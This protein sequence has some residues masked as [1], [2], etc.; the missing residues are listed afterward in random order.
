MSC[1][2]NKTDKI[3]TLTNLGLTHT[4]AKV[5]LN[6]CTFGTMNAK[7]VSNDSKTHRQDTYRVLNELFTLGLVEK[8]LNKP[9]EFRAIPLNEGLNL[10][11]ERRNEATRELKKESLRI[12]KSL[13]PTHLEKAEEEHKLIL[14]SSKE[15]ILTETEKLLTAVQKS[16]YVMSPPQSLVPWVFAHQELFEEASRRR[17]KVRFIT[18]RT[19]HDDLPK[20]L[21]F[22]SKHTNYEIKLIPNKPEV[23]F[24]IYDKKSIVF[25]LSTREGFL[26]SQV[27]VSDNPC[28]VELGLLAFESVWNQPERHTFTESRKRTKTLLIGPEA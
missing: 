18:M 16:L 6:I 3:Q 17:V 24:G 22:S 2:N 26:K 23:S 8:L 7:K 5:Y 1:K 19:K 11:L 20:A 15:T 28:L 13:D 4:Q 21:E 12:I 14:I 10:L 27:I 25:E 9:V